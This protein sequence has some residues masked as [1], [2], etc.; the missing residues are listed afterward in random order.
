[1]VLSCVAR[2]EEASL[3]KGLSRGHVIELAL[4]GPG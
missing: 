3:A 1:M 2:D 4:F